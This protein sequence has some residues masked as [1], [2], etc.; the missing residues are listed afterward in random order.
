MGPKGI[1]T[2]CEEKNGQSDILQYDK[3]VNYFLETP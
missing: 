2:G 1:T 3:G